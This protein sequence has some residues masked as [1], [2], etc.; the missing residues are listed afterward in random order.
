MS[1]G[2]PRIQRMIGSW[3]GSGRGTWAIR[4]P[5]VR[6]VLSLLWLIRLANVRVCSFGKIQSCVVLVAGHSKRWSTVPGW[7]LQ[8][9]H[10]VGAS[11]SLMRARRVCVHCPPVAADMSQGRL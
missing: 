3:R 8:R 9:L 2:L 6:R 1:L 5:V 7:D 10:R 4:V 11:Q